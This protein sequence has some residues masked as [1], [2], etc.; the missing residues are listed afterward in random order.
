MSRRKG[1][2]HD[3]AQL[4]SLL[5]G[6]V[7]AHS[8]YCELESIGKSTEGRELWLLTITDK[9]S[10]HHACKPAFWV[11]ANTHAGEV[12]GTEACLHFVDTLLAQLT[13][14]D[15]A[16]R[17]LVRTST[18]YALPRISVDG[19]ELYLT[20]P[21]SV[22]SSPVLFPGV[23]SVP[24]LVPEDI[25][26]NG[27][28]LVMRIPDPA[29][30]FKCSDEDE[31][32]MVPREPHEFEEGAT[33]YR[34]LPEGSF[35]HYDGF[36]QN[37]R[38]DNF[39]LN[40]Q[41]PTNFS[42]GGAMSFEGSG[43]TTPGAGPYPMYL[44]EAQYVVEAITARNNI[45]A[46]LTHHTTG[47]IL[48]MPGGADVEPSDFERF[49]TLNA[50][51]ESLTGYK[52]TNKMGS[53]GPMTVD[54]AYHHRGIMAWLPEIWNLQHEL[55][56]VE[57]AGDDIEEEDEDY[58]RECA[59]LATVLRWCEDHLPEGEY[60]EDWHP[61]DHPQLGPIEVGGFLFKQC[62]QN[63]P[64]TML[65]GEIR[66][67]TDWAM[68]LAKSLPRITVQPSLVSHL[69]GSGGGD[70]LAVLVRV[71]VS[72]QGFLPSCGSSMAIQTA[73]VRGTG[74]ATLALGPGQTLRAGKLRTEVPHLDGR[75]V[76]KSQ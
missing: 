18:V 44:P 29:G 42:P 43:G 20:T 55:G 24:G 28:L 62:F 36:T 10:G 26:G 16:T 1:H 72:N 52:V 32:I 64:P 60:F 73:S 37:G 58:D 2:Y 46:M 76:Q 53:P 59:N 68:T 5:E 57:L 41:F 9:S 3:Y 65:E 21:F 38:P 27:E 48:I 15:Y 25:D 51:G 56:L 39:D 47:R 69:Q 50:L 74:E 4:T 14:G 12:T 40:R 7:E 23:E 66:K 30:G 71:R 70:T 63:P 61:F 67:I 13:G 22:R 35:K 31:R 17:E 33:Y 19:A 8:N 34:L 49:E 6:W 75:S 45:V 11:E 54:W